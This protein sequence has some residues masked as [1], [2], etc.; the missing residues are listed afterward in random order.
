[1]IFL[2]IVYYLYSA[3]TY[4][5]MLLRII[6][7]VS[8]D[9][10]MSGLKLEFNYYNNL[11]LKGWHHRASVAGYD[12]FLAG[13]LSLPEGREFVLF[14]FYLTDGRYFVCISDVEMY[15][16]MLSLQNMPVRLAGLVFCLVLTY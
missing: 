10:S 2:L 5:L 16:M 9:N 12:G 4:N 13:Y 14:S 7:K 8:Y 3:N 15:K 1:M 11:I 6:I